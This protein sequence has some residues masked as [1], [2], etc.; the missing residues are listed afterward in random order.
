ASIVNG[1][2]D[3]LFPG[4]R[5]ALNQHAGIGGCNDFNLPQD[6]LQSRASSDDLVKRRPTPLLTLDV[7]A[8]KIKSVFELLQFRAKQAVGET[9]RNLICRQRQQLHFLFGTVR[10]V[11]G[12]AEHSQATLVCLQR[13]TAEP[14]L[15]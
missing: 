13:Q 7:N 2:C 12:N 9:K 4:A 1:L 8:V 6:P 14:T 5:L 15:S 11:D 3:E 10:L